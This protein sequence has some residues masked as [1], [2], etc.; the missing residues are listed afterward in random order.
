MPCEEPKP[1]PLIVTCW[2]AWALEVLSEVTTGPVMAVA[3]VPIEKMCSWLALE[4]VGRV[5]LVSV[6]PWLTGDRV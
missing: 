2:P 4:P 3:E 6:L 1:E 5:T